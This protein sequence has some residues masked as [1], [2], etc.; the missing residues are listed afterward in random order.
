MIDD[1]ILDSLIP[2]PEEKEIMDRIKHDLSENGFKV[3]KWDSGGVFYILTRI[4]VRCHVVRH[5]TGK[6]LLL[7]GQDYSKERKAATKT[8]GYITITRSSSSEQLLIPKGHMFKTPDDING[9]ALKYYALNDTVI[10]EGANTGTI[11]VEAEKAGTD[12]NVS[13]NMITISMVYLE[14][15]AEVANLTNWIY[16][17]GADVEDEESFR[18]RVLSSWNELATNTTKAKLKNVVEGVEGVLCAY[19]DDMHP[20]GQGTVDIIVTGTAGAASESLLSAVRDTTNRIRDNYE[21]YLVKSAVVVHQNFKFT[22][23]IDAQ[24]NTDGVIEQSKKLLGKHMQLAGREL[25]VLLHEDISYVL[26]SN[27]P[28]YRK[29]VFETPESDVILEHGKVILLGDMHI[30]IR[31]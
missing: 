10:G 13:E 5:A 12:Y 31:S 7:K 28:G 16:Q 29:M 6:W 30:S 27:I 9:N 3:T 4:V 22:I 14:G 21:D 19:I 18:R 25:N 26:K 23:Y 2:I 24:A 1:S 17:E 8:Q 20:R 15:G 11:L